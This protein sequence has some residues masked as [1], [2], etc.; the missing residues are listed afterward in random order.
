MA[1][2]RR[3]GRAVREAES[4][5][6]AQQ[7]QQ[8]L[9]SCCQVLWLKNGVLLCRFQMGHVVAWMDPTWRQEGQLAVLVAMAQMAAHPQLAQNCVLPHFE[10]CFN[11]LDM[12]RFIQLQIANRITEVVISRNWAVT[13]LSKRQVTYW[14]WPNFPT[15]KVT[16]WLGAPELPSWLCFLKVPD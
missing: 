14:I 12:V 2:L 9:I 10:A 1:L 7:L 8:L 6:L 16:Q 3:A 4:M 11:D 13:M 5:E 15:L